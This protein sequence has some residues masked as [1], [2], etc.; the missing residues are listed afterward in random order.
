M[1]GALGTIAKTVSE[2]L[3]FS[4]YSVR[5]GLRDGANTRALVPFLC[6]IGALPGHNVLSV[7]Y[8][9]RAP[10]SLSPTLVDVAVSFGHWC[11]LSL[12]FACVRV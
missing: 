3:G 8:Q 7:R 6:P 4:L 11:I 10:L 2:A 1:A 9:T 12:A 5:P